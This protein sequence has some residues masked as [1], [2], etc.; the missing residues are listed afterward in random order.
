MNTRLI[1]LYLSPL[2]PHSVTGQSLNQNQNIV[3]LSFMTWFIILIQA[4]QVRLGVLGRGTWDL[5]CPMNTGNAFL[6]SFIHV[7]FYIWFTILMLNLLKYTPLSAMHV[8]VIGAS[9]HQC[10]S[11]IWYENVLNYSITGL[12][13]LKR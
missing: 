1:W 5:S 13:H 2:N 6:I 4:L 11:F 3:S 10:I 7:R 9:I 12:K 8:P